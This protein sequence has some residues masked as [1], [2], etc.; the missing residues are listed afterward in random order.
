M[1]LAIALALAAILSLPLAL[2]AAP[3]GAQ[4]PASV[5]TSRPSSGIH[6]IRLFA[7][8]AC[9]AESFEATGAQERDFYRRALV[10]WS[11]FEVSEACWLTLPEG[12]TVTLYTEGLI[13]LTVPTSIFRPEQ[14]A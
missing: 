13:E 6:L 14:H 2:H 8:E 12:G 10:V 5:I 9:S 11:T 7:D 3:V 1:G 4:P